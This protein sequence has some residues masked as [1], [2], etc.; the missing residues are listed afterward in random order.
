MKTERVLFKIHQKSYR[1]KSSESNFTLLRCEKKKTE[2][3]RKRKNDKKT[4]ETLSRR[5]LFSKKKK[6]NENTDYKY[7]RENSIYKNLKETEEKKNT[8]RKYFNPFNDPKERGKKLLCSFNN[9]LQSSR[10][11]DDD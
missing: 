8:P 4:V 3:S 5:I 6:L 11:F 2:E 1:F 7:K 10:R 9:N